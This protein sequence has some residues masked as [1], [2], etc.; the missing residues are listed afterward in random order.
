MED[1]TDFLSLDLFAKRFGLEDKKLSYGI[2]TIAGEDKPVVHIEGEELFISLPSDSI[3]P[4]ETLGIQIE[5]CELV[6]VYD[7]EKFDEKILVGYSFEAPSGKEILVSL[8]EVEKFYANKYFSF[9][10]LKYIRGY[11]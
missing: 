6:E 2:I 4:T 10:T 9:A 3:L 5:K 11:Y 7:D 1:R 8:E